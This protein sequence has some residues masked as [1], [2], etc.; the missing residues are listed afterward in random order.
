MPHP[1]TPAPPPDRRPEEPEPLGRPAPL[2]EALDGS[3]RSVESG[4]SGAPADSPRSGAPAE[5]ER[6]YQPAAPA[7]SAWF[8]EPAERDR[9]GAPAERDRTG[10]PA[11]PDRT[12]EPAE[13]AD[14]PRSG[15]PAESDRAGTSGHRD[16]SGP[17]ANSD[18]PAHSGPSGATAPSDAR[19]AGA[20]APTGADTGW[21]PRLVRLG[22]PR[23]GPAARGARRFGVPL[24]PLLVAGL[25]AT[26]FV[27]ARG[28]TEQSPSAGGRPGGDRIGVPSPVGSDGGTA[29][30]TPPAGRAPTATGTAGTGTDG[31]RAAD[32]PTAG[33]SAAPT[34]TAAPRRTGELRKASATPTRT[35]GTPAAP[36]RTRPATQ[37]GAAPRPVSFEALRVGECFDIDRGAPGT[38]V[39]RSCDTPHHAELVAR[40]RLTGRHAT[41]TAIREAAALLCRAPLRG[42]AAR[43]PIGTRWTT[44]VQYPYRTSYL[45]GSDAVACSLAA[46]GGG[47]LSR[48]LQ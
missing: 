43:Q 25:V 11:E 7:D 36:R 46:T 19:G 15:A 39:R 45:L 42:K 14:S 40:L 2:P 17:S 41:D 13:P 9:T 1:S 20:D 47:T 24:V 18:A 22:A 4:P 10:E 33:A 23:P 5:S 38:A 34:R 31:G 21:S 27:A 29:E 48:P 28:G 8:G 44:F 35:G 16:A 32:T 30:A 37:G 26:A 6:A 12:G 3:G